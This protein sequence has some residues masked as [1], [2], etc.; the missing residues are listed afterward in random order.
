MRVTYMTPN[1]NIS[2][3][4]KAKLEHCTRLAERG[5]Q[6]TMVVC[7]STQNLW[8]KWFP[9]N[10]EIGVM[11]I[12]PQNLHSQMP[13]ADVLIANHWPYC[14]NLS[15]KQG[16]LLVP[17]QIEEPLTVRELEEMKRKPDL[18][19][20][21]SPDVEKAMYL[22]NIRNM[23]L[24][25]NGVNHEL[26]NPEGR[27]FDKKILTQLNLKKRRKGGPETLEVLGEIH[28]RYPSVPIIGFGQRTRTKHG[29]VPK[30]MEFHKCGPWE[31]SKLYKE[32]GIFFYAALLDGFANSPA[33]AMASGC[34]TVTVKNAGMPYVSKYSASTFVPGDNK[35]AYNLLCATLDRWDEDDMRWVKQR[36]AAAVGRMGPYSWERSVDQLEEA[37]RRAVE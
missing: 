34:I 22:Q 11:S 15:P 33:E 31:L 14:Q 17:R 26:F 27:T 36:S 23:H 13:K 2:G 28:K 1:M 3:G 12:R 35:K 32:C 25:Q 8:P 5:H 18:W 7:K 19:L 4:V 6:V 20:P 10:K 21:N 37:M 29:K 30:W 9:L 24:V 16:R